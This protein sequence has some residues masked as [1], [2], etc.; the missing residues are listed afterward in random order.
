VDTRAEVPVAIHGR[1]R[2]VDLF[3][4]DPAQP[5]DD[6]VVVQFEPV[7]DGR[8]LPVAGGGSTKPRRPLP[9]PFTDDSAG[10]STMRRTLAG[11]VLAIGLAAPLQAQ[12]ADIEGVIQGQIDAFLADDFATA[13]GFAS[14]AIRGI[15]RDPDRFGTMVREGY[16]MVWRPAEV[17]F[18]DLEE[19]SG[20][21]VQKVLIR[22][23]EGAL[24]VLAYQMLQTETGWQINGV[25]IL[26]A[27][28]LS[29]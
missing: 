13:F 15:F 8:F 12:D 9:F 4:G 11:L 3:E 27:P 6:V 1:D 17:T 29:A 26:R 14:P 24:H 25:S 7:G 5:V 22:D 20:R 23:R 10:R 16:P 18:L 19:R 28:G 2:A 21:V